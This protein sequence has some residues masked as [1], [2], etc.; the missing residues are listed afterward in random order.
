MALFHSI[1]TADG[2]EE[3]LRMDPEGHTQ[4][5]GIHLQTQAAGHLPVDLQKRD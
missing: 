1:Y 5:P 4:V 3:P 2:E